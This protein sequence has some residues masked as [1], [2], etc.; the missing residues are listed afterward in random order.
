MNKKYLES[1]PES[2]SV[3]KLGDLVVSQK[4]KK[5]K[6]HTKSKTLKN[7]MPY[8][9]IEAFEKGVFNS[10]TDGVG[11]QICTEADFLMVWDGSRSGLVGKGIY[12][13]LGSTLVKINFPHINNRYAFF[14]LQSKY[15]EI[16][17]RA[18]GSGTPH[19][20]PNLLWNYDFPIPPLSEQ[21]RIVEKIEELFSNLD[22]AVSILQATKTKIA[23]YKQL[24]LK[25]AFSGGLTRV[26]GRNVNYEDI[27][28]EKILALKN[29]SAPK[30]NK[31][32]VQMGGELSDAPK[33][34]QGW[35]WLRLSDLCS[36]SGGITKNSKRSSASIKR[37]FLRVANVYQNELRLSDIHEIGLEESELKRVELRAGDIL[38][39]EGNGSVDQIG[40]AALWD[41]SIVGCV[42]QNHLIKARSYGAID[43]RYIIQYLMSEMGRRNIVKVA[44]STSGLYTLNL[45]KIENL[46]I[47]YCVPAEQADVI[48]SLSSLVDAM[49]CIEKSIDDSLLMAEQLRQS[50]LNKAFSGR[51]VPQIDEDESASILLDRA[52]LEANKLKSITKRSRA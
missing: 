9:D 7:I 41:G 25:E 26:S 49:S 46:L 36:V 51:I 40:R 30:K 5:P 13:A 29:L 27:S 33:L 39:V 4:G 17:T 50:I 19:V 45:S 24:V 6:N 14:F 10:W 32:N 11:C 15:R 28:L 42:H 3:V 34:P 12:G 43:P 37:P 21:S 38:L 48:N 23:L 8:V 31:K 35:L 20:D 44:S 47:P 22:G 16:N 1:L 18:K 52:R 2:W